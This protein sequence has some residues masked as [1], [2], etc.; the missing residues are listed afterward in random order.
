MGNRYPTNLQQRALVWGMGS[1]RCIMFIE[2]ICHVW[3]ATPQ[4]NWEWHNLYR[5]GVQRIDPQLDIGYS[6]FYS[7]PDDAIQ[8]AAINL[9]DC[10]TLP[11]QVSR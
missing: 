6:Y 5:I 7:L 1:V 9:P 8:C 4:M 10:I 3:C 11:L 2:G